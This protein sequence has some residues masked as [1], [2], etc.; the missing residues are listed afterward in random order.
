MGTGSKF[1]AGAG[2]S[3]CKLTV[4]L[5]SSK[6]ERRE[7]RATSTERFLRKNGIVIASSVDNIGKEMK[8]MKMR[9]LAATLDR[10]EGFCKEVQSVAGAECP[11]SLKFLTKSRSHAPSATDSKASAA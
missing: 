7:S 10:T 4:A 3:A 6:Q 9:R 8:G 1:K 5:Q 2:D 11:N